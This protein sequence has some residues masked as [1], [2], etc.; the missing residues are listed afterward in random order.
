M[1]LRGRSFPSFGL[2][3]PLAVLGLGAVGQVLVWMDR[4]Q[5]YRW[6]V[7]A[8]LVVMAMMVWERRGE[9]RR[10]GRRVDAEGPDAGAPGEGRDGAVG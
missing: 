8:L 4:A 5:P 3:L 10:I 6:S 2:L 7:W 1:V 9:L